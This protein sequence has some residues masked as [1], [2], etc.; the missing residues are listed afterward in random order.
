MGKVL[1]VGKLGVVAL[2]S[3]GWTSEASVRADRITCNGASW[4][5]YP[6]AQFC[7]ILGAEGETGVACSNEN[8]DGS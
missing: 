3:R 6:S 2:G 5:L 4:M 1:C 7:A 8:G